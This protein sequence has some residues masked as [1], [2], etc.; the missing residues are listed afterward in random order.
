MLTGKRI[1]IIISGGIAAYKSL[2]LI[3]RLRERGAAVR[4]VM[5]PA[6]AH[7]VTPLSVAA[8]CEDKVY[9]DLWSLTEES[10]MGHMRL[11]SEAELIGVEP[12][13]DECNY[14]GASGNPSQSRHLGGA[15]RQADRSGFG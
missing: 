14:V 8:L 7:F 12:A 13:G 2:E 3:R 10:E 9:T 4:P 6:A 15:R 5:T 1:M 11:S